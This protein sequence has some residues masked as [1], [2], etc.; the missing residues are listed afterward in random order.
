MSKISL[1]ILTKYINKVIILLVRNAGKIYNKKRKE[2]TMRKILALILTATM[3]FA[4]V[5][6]CFAA[7]APTFGDVN[8]DGVANSKDLTRLMKF[9]AGEDVSVRNAD[10]NYDRVLNSKDLTRLMK[11]IA[12]EELTPVNQDL[13][14][15]LEDIELSVKLSSDFDRTSEADVNADELLAGILVNLAETTA[16]D[17]SV[18]FTNTSSYSGVLASLSSIVGRVRVNSDENGMPDQLTAVVAISTGDTE[19]VSG[20]KAHIAYNDGTA[21]IFAEDEEN[22]EK[23]YIEVGDIFGDT[24]IPGDGSE[25]IPGIDD[26]DPDMLEMISGLIAELAEKIQCK[27]YNTANGYAIEYTLDQDAIADLISGIVT[28]DEGLPVDADIPEI[29]VSVCVFVTADGE[30]IGLRADI[31]SETSFEIDENTTETMSDTTE[32]L[33]AVNVLGRD[34]VVTLPAD[35]ADYTEY[36]EEPTPDYEEIYL[37]V[38]ALYDENG[39]K[40]EYFDTVYSKLCNKYTKEVVDE[41]ISEVEYGFAYSAVLNTL[42][43]CDGTRVENYDELYAILCEKYGSE[44]VDPLINQFENSYDDMIMYEIIDAL[45]G[46]D[47]THVE[48]YD[49]VYAALCE[50]Y[51]KEVVDAVI[52]DR[53]YNIAYFTVTETLYNEYGERV[54]NFDELY[55]ALC[56]Q[57]NAEMIDSIIFKIEN[58]TAIYEIM[59]TLFGE[60]AAPVENYDEVYAGLVTEYGQELV[61]EAVTMFYEM[62]APV[63]F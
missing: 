9:I 56:E 48:N 14:A 21:Y 53:E 62:F 8:T 43:N 55:A 58:S 16:A 35:L 51:T 7:G 27:V 1:I 41:M 30:L 2:L 22:S 20:G 31:A 18:Q 45:F 26:I 34:V 44:F 63:E 17:L 38:K 50:L 61:D 47:G 60:D 32:I 15:E 57:Y 40:V 54:D 25:I 12:G 5:L 6:P 36:V 3:L 19:N 42:F 49:E 52:S 46:E 11:Y 4:M 37:A 28:P 23:F 10:V 59:D 24:E 39:N 13:F 33:V 29:N